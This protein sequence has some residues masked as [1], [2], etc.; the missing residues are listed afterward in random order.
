MHQ[1]TLSITLSCLSFFMMHTQCLACE[2]PAEE[3]YRK[4]A[5]HPYSTLQ[6]RAYYAYV[7]ETRGVEK[8]EE[9]WRDWLLARFTKPKR[10]RD[11]DQSDDGGINFD[12]RG[13]ITDDEGYVVA[14][15][16]EDGRLI[17][18]DSEGDDDDSDATAPATPTTPPNTLNRRAFPA[19]VRQAASSDLR[20]PHAGR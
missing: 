16:D 1:S 19:L 14:Y 12:R 15:E 2:D 6:Y 17:M 11:E 10:K 5:T 18:V 20:D 13:H 7:E 8:D 4:H 9:M 3:I